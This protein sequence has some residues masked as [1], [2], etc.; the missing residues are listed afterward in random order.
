MAEVYF[1][2]RDIS[3]GNSNAVI[4]TKKETDYPVIASES[5]LFNCHDQSLLL[6]DVY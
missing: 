2:Q 5:W 4:K 3:E 1:Y 6:I